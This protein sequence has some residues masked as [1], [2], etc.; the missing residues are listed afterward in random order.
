MQDAVRL[1]FKL[2]CDRHNLDLRD[3]VEYSIEYTATLAVE[4]HA[5]DGVR[6]DPDDAYDAIVEGIRSSA[7]RRLN[8]NSV[9]QPIFEPRSG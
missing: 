9:G 5:D 3:L 1:S 6:L 2:L 7:E 4:D 8:V